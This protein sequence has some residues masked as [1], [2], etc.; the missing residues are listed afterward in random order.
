MKGSIRDFLL[1]CKTINFGKVRLS[2]TE[3]TFYQQF[4][5]EI[6]ALCRSLPKAAQTDAILFLM[7]YS[8]A[9]LSDKLDFFANYYSPTWSI[10]YWLS[11]NYTFPRQQLKKSDI[12]NAV[13]AQSMAMLLHSLDDH[14]IDGQVSASPLTLLLRS[15]AWTIMNRAFRNLAEGVPAGEEAVGSFIDAY[16]TSI[17]DSHRPESLDSYCGLFRN[18]MSIGMIASILLSMKMTGNPDFTRD[19]EMA[20]GSFGVAW[21]LLDD[22]RD[23]GD[24]IKNGAHTSIYLCLPEEV[25]THWNNNATRSRATAR[26]S[27]NAVMNH[28]L[29]NGLIDKIKE[30]IC[31]ELETAASIVEAHNITGLAREF[32]CLADPLRKNGSKQEEYYGRPSLSLASK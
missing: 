25:R 7:C 5:K 21:R 22:I 1:H 6:I 10:L 3:S 8:R 16:Y 28:I 26:I 31:S 17:R 29:E 23:I 19:I 20:Y 11:H 27:T 24:D 15:Q 2:K 12:T 13:T 18:Q 9:I 30:R 4:S 32:R 14:L